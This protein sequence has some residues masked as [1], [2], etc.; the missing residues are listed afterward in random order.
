MNS[1]R[2]LT[3]LSTFILCSQ[4]YSQS[5]FH[6]TSP[7]YEFF[8]QRDIL[9]NADLWGKEPKI[10][11]AGLGFTKILGIPGLNSP[12][13]ELLCRLFGG[14]WNTVDGDN[15]PLRAYTSAA[16][17]VSIRIAYGPWVIGQGGFPVEFSW[18]V[19]P[20]TV[21]PE[22]FRVTLNDGSEVTPA[23]ASIFPNF[24]YNERSTVVLVGEFGNRL[25]PSEDSEALYPVKLDIVESDIPLTLIGLKGIKK[26]ATGFSFGDGETPMTAY[27]TGSGPVLCAAK[28]S[29]MRTAGENGPLPFRGVLPNDGVALYGED[30][31]FRLRV[32]TTGGFS[33][34]GVA[35]VLPTDFER[36]FRIRC[37][38][39]DGQVIWITEAN[40]VYK[41]MGKTLE[42][43]GLA[44]LGKTES[45]DP[46]TL[47]YSEDH[48]NQ[49]DIILKGDVEAMHCITHVHIPA[50]G[51][52]TP[53]YNPGGPGNT[54][55]PGTIYT[56][57]G[58]EFLQPVLDAIDHP[59]T[60][61]WFGQNAR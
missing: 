61:T 44:D 14:T 50:S 16:T 24:E 7:L 13:G 10:I 59:Y 8:L 46:Y 54:P 34:D 18:P 5:I 55:T 28:I 15:V 22:N 39:P 47:A 19:Q 32:L 53:F 25:N 43:L 41:Y 45:D 42:V 21:R 3:V 17:I 4:T 35:S 26:I 60:V 38:A 40:K 30:A 20:S 52:Y 31:Q 36:F 58:S 1:L 57:P 56:N 23:G 6:S 33:P 12:Y 2:T 51:D 9:I 27:N 11:G 37:E 48:D 29:K 49:I